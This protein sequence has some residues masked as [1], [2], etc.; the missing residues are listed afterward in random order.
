[1]VACDYGGVSSTVLLLMI[2]ARPT[3]KS[4]GSLLQETNEFSKK[5][6][7]LFFGSAARVFGTLQF[8]LELFDRDGRSECSYFLQFDQQIEKFNKRKIDLRFILKM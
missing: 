7:L 4:Y 3:R 6:Y 5:G 2:L 8:L 1:M